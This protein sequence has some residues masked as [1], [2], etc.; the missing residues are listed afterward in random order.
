MPKLCPLNKEGEHGNFKEC[1]E[2]RCAWYNDAIGGCEIT[3]LSL[4]SKIPIKANTKHELKST[5]TKRVF[6]EKRA[7]SDS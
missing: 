7:L 6:L 1:L 4:I 5:E 3:N 2:E